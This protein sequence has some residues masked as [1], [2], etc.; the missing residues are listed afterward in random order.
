M[1]RPAAIAARAAKYVATMDVVICRSEIPSIS[2]P[3]DQMYAVS[4]VA[5]PSSM[6][7][8]LSRGR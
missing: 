6:M 3:V 8:A 1:S 2:T 7:F 5:T 4:P